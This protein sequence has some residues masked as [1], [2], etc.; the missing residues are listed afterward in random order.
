MVEFDFATLEHRLRELAFLNSGVTIVLSDARHAVEKREQLHYEGGVEE[1]VKYLD[2]N[3]TGLIPA[4]I[5]IKTERSGIG[6]ECALWWNDGYH[7]SVLCFT[8]NIPQRDGG[9]H[10]AASAAR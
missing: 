1:F 2:R 3:K 5:V 9:T 6:V 10:L 8:N 4:P 7:E